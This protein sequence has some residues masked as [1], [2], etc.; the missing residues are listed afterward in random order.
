MNYLIASML[1]SFVVGLIVG[2]TVEARARGH[3]VKK[4]RDD[5]GW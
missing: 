3:Y 4:G 5:D 2:V 1:A